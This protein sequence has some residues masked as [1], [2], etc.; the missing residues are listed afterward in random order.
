MNTTTALRRQIGDTWIAWGLTSDGDPVLDAL[1]QWLA[2][3]GGYS[4]DGKRP[5]AEPLD[6]PTLLR[7]IDQL[8]AALPVASDTAARAE[9]LRAGRVARAFV[10]LVA[11]TWPGR[12]DW[13]RASA[14]ELVVALVATARA[15]PQEGLDGGHFAALA[16]WV[17]LASVS[18][19]PGL[20]D[21]ATAHGRALEYAPLTIAAWCDALDAA[22]QRLLVELPERWVPVVTEFAVALRAL[23]V[24]VAG[25]AP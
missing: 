3:S 10:P 6:G 17:T 18:L 21:A 23:A 2:L 1:W 12:R 9:L 5:T 19:A 8:E 24:D 4:L 15:W 22:T 14:D 25:G 13:S 7:A 20:S 16:G 11:P